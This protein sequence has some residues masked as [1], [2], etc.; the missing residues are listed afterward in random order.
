[1]LGGSFGLTPGCSGPNCVDDRAVAALLNQDADA[2]VDAKARPRTRDDCRET[3]TVEIDEVAAGSHQ[4]LVDG[5]VRATI[6]L[7]ATG[8]GEIELDTNDPLKPVLNFDR[9]GREIAIAKNRVLYFVHVFP[10]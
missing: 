3:F 8:R 1:M 6:A 10:E 7:G 5:S 4:R 2:N 9:R